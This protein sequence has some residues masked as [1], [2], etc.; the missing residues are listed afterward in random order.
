MVIILTENVGKTAKLQTR[1]ASRD[2]KT[3]IKESKGV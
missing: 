1:W 3:L 2:M